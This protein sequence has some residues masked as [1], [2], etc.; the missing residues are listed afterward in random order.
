MASDLRL[1]P[2]TIDYGSASSAKTVVASVRNNYLYPTS[3]TLSAT[4]PF[5]VD[6]GLTSTYNNQYPIHR[7]DVDEMF[8]QVTNGHQIG[9]LFNDTSG[10]LMFSEYDV[11][12][13][14]NKLQ[15]VSSGAVEKAVVKQY[16]STLEGN[17]NYFIFAISGTGTIATIY[18]VKRS[19]SGV[20]TFTTQTPYTIGSGQTLGDFIGDEAVIYSSSSSLDY[21]SHY[22]AAIQHTSGSNDGVMLI[23]MRFSGIGYNAYYDIVVDNG[24]TEYDKDPVKMTGIKMVDSVARASLINSDSSVN[25]LVG[26]L[27]SVGGFYNLESDIDYTVDKIDALHD[28]EN[29]LLGGVEYDGADSILHKRRYEYERMLFYAGTNEY[30]LTTPS[31]NTTDYI[32]NITATIG[33]LSN[34]TIEFGYYVS[35]VWNTLGTYTLTG[36][37]DFLESTIIDNEIAQIGT[38]VRI[39]NSASQY[40]ISNFIIS[41]GT[42]TYL[43]IDGYNVNV[44]VLASG[45]GEKAYA[46]T[47]KDYD[48]TPDTLVGVVNVSHVAVFNY[49]VMAILNDDDTHNAFYSRTTSRTNIIS[50]IVDSAC[51]PKTILC[52]WSGT[53]YYIGSFITGNDWSVSVFDSNFSRTD[54]AF[55]LNTSIIGTASYGAHES[56]VVASSTA[57]GHLIATM[58]VAPVLETAPYG[59][60]MFGQ[61]HKDFARYDGTVENTESYEYVGSGGTHIYDDI[62]CV[63]VADANGTYNIK[64]LQNK[65]M[66][67]SDSF[68][69]FIETINIFYDPTYRSMMVND[70]TIKA[71]VSMAIS[72][73]PNVISW[74]NNSNYTTNDYKGW[75]TSGEL[76]ETGDFSNDVIYVAGSKQVVVREVVVNDDNAQAIRIRVEVGLQ[77]VDGNDVFDDFRVFQV[78]LLAT[79]YFGIGG[80]NA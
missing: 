18:S 39:S 66:D 69:A 20:W 38:H 15:V 47:S 10:N 13:T 17:R 72:K 31:G 50:S 4:T 58:L 74:G 21:T 53:N 80:D 11:D 45:G 75:F 54:D 44:G 68:D 24:G 27:F 56:D 61:Q 32:S 28:G 29:I 77:D 25:F 41:D 78:Q 60:I 3:D 55:E 5:N 40:L 71:L 23:S 9:M 46:M 37:S 12:G 22:I 8:Q 34:L 48:D 43:S 57:I 6:G 51:D 67:E 7:D 65:V 52:S 2:S 79:G 70:T 30:Q 36:G 16:F 62:E 14:L 35:T 59:M 76:E 33:T 1:V 42:T 73:H 63:F 64:Y 19:S 26:N 49:D